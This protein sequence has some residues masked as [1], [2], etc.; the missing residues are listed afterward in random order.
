MYR[1]ICAGDL[2]HQLAI[3]T[4]FE[5]QSETGTITTQELRVLAIVWGR[6]EPITGKELLA[7]QQ[8]QSKVNTRA[9]VRYR[10]DL[11]TNMLIQY[12]DFTY[13]IEA[14]I[15]DERFADSLTLLLSSGVAN[16]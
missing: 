16:L 10:T 9:T 3:L 12:G 7:A 6:L 15:P 5:A 11:K 4:P 14:I 13:T 2:T 8:V 1:A